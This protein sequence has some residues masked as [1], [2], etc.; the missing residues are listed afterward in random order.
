VRRAGEPSAQQRFLAQRYGFE[1]PQGFT[2][3]RPHERG[4]LP[5]VARVR[6]YRSRSASKM[7][8]EE[9]ETSPEGTRPAWF[10]FEKDCASLLKRRDMTVI[11]QAVHRDGDGGVDLYATDAAGQSWIVQCKCWAAH[12]RVGPQVV[13]EL[14][15]AIKLADRGFSMVSRGLIITTS[16]FSDGARQTAHTLG[17]E[18]IDGAQLA[19]LLARLA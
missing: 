1:I 13:R 2:F 4:A 8:F 17:F 16:S 18:L 3:V 19:S 12:R 5:E 7:I 15:G 6:K 9:L 11:H 10:D 14:E